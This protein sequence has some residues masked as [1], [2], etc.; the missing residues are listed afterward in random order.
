MSE[1]T[2]RIPIPD[3]FIEEV[4]NLNILSEMLDIETDIT[5][6]KIKDC[7]AKYDKQGAYEAKQEMK[8][9]VKEQLKNHEEKWAAIGRAVPQTKDGAWTLDTHDYTLRKKSRPRLP[10]GLGAGLGAIIGE[11]AAR[12]MAEDD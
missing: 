7:I 6:Q 5:Q 3:E 12:Q 10:D 2:E 1:K 9:L 11:A 4:K 8:R